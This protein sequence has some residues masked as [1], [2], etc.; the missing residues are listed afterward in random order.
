MNL[1]AQ[2]QTCLQTHFNPGYLEVI[3]ESQRHRGSTHTE[4]HFRVII[5]SQQFSK[6]TLLARHRLCNQ[7]LAKER[8][9][10]IHALALSTYTPAE[11][12]AKT[13]KPQ[14]PPCRGRQESKQ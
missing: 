2:I 13:Q 3:N 6:L 14:S 9:Q 11:W 7:L 12:Q 1:S 5:V 4:S 8:A 10:G